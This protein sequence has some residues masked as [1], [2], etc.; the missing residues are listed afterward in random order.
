M[1]TLIQILSEAEYVINNIPK[2]IFVIPP[3][4]STSIL[5]KGFREAK[6]KYP[7]I[8]PIKNVGLLK[9]LI[10]KSRKKPTINNIEKIWGLQIG[11]YYLICLDYETVGNF[12]P[13]IINLML[14]KNK[15]LV[16]SSS[17]ARDLI[18]KIKDFLK[19]KK[20]KK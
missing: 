19:K 4:R 6:I 10:K 12:K 20:K 15:K 8:K 1:K 3:E 9:S 13:K 11:R 18:L 17:S 16:V 5:E 7:K 2:S 14:R